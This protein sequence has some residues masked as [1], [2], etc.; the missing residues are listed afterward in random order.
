MDWIVVLAAVLVLLLVGAALQAWFAALSDRATRS[1][2]A[3]EAQA[4]E[5]EGRVLLE[6]AGYRVLGEQV[7]LGWSY[8]LNGEIVEALLIA[9]FLV[10]RR[11]RRYVAD[12]KTGGAA[13][14]RN[15]ATRRQLLEYQLA[16]DVTAVLLVDLERRA[17]HELRF[18][19]QR[20]S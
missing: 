5:R 8:E 13:S 11:G 4:G 20:V 9:D 14:L 7:R 3:L 16:F 12:A 2:R 6:A 19:A 15:I 10:E 1:Q 17:I 18:L